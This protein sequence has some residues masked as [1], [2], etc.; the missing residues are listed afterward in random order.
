MKI[1]YMGSPEV[2]AQLL[3]RLLKKHKI[4]SIYTRKPA[5]KNRGL[6]LVPSAV[7]KVALNH[8]IPV[9][10]PG[11]L[12]KS[13]KNQKAFIEQ[14]FD[15][16]IVFA[17][18]LILPPAVFNSPKH[19]IINVHVSLLPRWRGAA[20]IERSIEAGDLKT[21][22]TIMRI[23][24]GLDDGDIIYQQEIPLLENTTAEQVY[25]QVVSIGSELLD[26][27]INTL[28]KGGSLPSLP[29]DNSLATYAPPIDTADGHLNFKK[30]TFSLIRQVNA[31]A[32]APGCY[33][34]YNGDC[35]KVLAVCRPA[36]EV[37][38][39][40]VNDTPVFNGLKPGQ[41]LSNKNGLY[42]KTS[43]SFL[44]ITKI[45]RTGKKPLEIKAFLSGYKFNNADYVS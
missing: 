37:L 19:G 10:C 43:D 15:L 20:P 9:C 36:A 35:L 13:V 29:Q 45:Q 6:K 7:N 26:K 18:G 24:E 21:G 41:L 11:T 22:V 12:R 4:S 32:R 8:H 33:F 17:Y 42:I 16:G 38:Q 34:Y 1:C 23:A 5:A 14:E 27:A 44:S 30:D 40:L 2:S 3:E 25:E 28:K 31:F 39:Q